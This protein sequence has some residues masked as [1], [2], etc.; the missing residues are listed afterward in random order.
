[1]ECIHVCLRSSGAREG[2]LW[3]PKS[4]EEAGF[5]TSN[6]HQA[7]SLPKPFDRPTVV[8]DV[9]NQAIVEVGKNVGMLKIG[10][11]TREW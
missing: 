4:A 1:M 7:M 2:D 6:V 11:H 9:G 3:K 10:I 8:A 5:L